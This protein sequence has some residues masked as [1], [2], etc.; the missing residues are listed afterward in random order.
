MHVESDIAYGLEFQ[1]VM[2]GKYLWVTLQSHIVMDEFMCKQ[3]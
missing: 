3:F 2:M 1:V